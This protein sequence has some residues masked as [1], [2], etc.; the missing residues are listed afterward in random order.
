M[1]RVT[2]EDCLKF[3]KNRFELVLV[4]AQRAHQLEMGSS[5]PLVPLDNDKPTVVAL[6]EIASGYDVDKAIQAAN[7]EYDDEALAQD[8]QGV[9]VSAVFT[10][11]TEKV[12]FQSDNDDIAALA[13]EF[14]ALEVSVDIEPEEAK[15][16]HEETTDESSKDDENGHQ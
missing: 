10:A 11:T 5:D 16:A 13:A 8:E 15:P 7:Q 12:E 2:V 4:A 3:V 6:R 1:A 14:S 9:D